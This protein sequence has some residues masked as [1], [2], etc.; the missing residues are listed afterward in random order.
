LIIP[1][2]PIRFFTDQPNEIRNN[3]IREHS[4]NTNSMSIS[5][6][7]RIVQNSQLERR[8]EEK[9]EKEVKKLLEK[10]NN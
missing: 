7:R 1:I 2:P 6:P 3:L 8:H 10:L 4:A 5:P 9:R